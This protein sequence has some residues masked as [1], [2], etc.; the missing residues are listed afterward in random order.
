MCFSAPASFAASAVLAVAGTVALR[1]VRRPGQWALAGIPL[2]FA[3]QQLFEGFVWLRLS[4]DGTA[5]AA[6]PCARAFL[7][8][9]EVVWPVWVP[10]AMLLPEQDRARRRWLTGALVAGLLIGAYLGW[11]L[12]AGPPQATILG[13]HIHYTVRYPAALERFGSAVYFIVTVPAVFM[14]GVR[15]MWVLGVALL[16]SYVVARSSFPGNVVS[17]WCYFAA[18]IS[19]VIIYLLHSG[20]GSRTQARAPSDLRTPSV[21]VGPIG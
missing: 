20:N 9:A 15:R 8:F 19:I 16:L 6:V 13:H 4:A 12:F 21:P 5:A 18:I 10:L 11:W 3:V 1:M 2:L 17:V 7:F 14:S